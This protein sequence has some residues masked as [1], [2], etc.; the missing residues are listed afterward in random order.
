MHSPNPKLGMAAHPQRSAD[1]MSTSTLRIANGRDDL[2]SQ[3]RVLTAGTLAGTSLIVG[4]SDPIGGGPPC[5]VSQCP[6]PS[7]GN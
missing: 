5:V 6:R 3:L 7:Q 4:L 1:P 2:L